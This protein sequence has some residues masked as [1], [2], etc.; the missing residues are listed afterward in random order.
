MNRIGTLLL[1]LFLSIYSFGQSLASLSDFQGRQNKLY[2]KNRMPHAGYWQQDV[3]Y[4]MKV[5]ID[6]KEESVAGTENLTY[7]NNSPDTLFEVFF[8]LYQ[9]AFTPGSYLHNSRTTEK[10]S[11][12]FGVHEAKG[13]GTA[14]N[15]L[16]VKQGKAFTEA[17]FEIDNSIMR[18]TLD[19]PIPPNSG[20]EFEIQFATYWDKGDKGN[21]RRRMK[22]FRHGG[23]G[24]SSFL[25]LDGVHWYPRI[26]VY[27]RKFGWT[28]DQHLG[29]EFYGD[30]GIYDVELNFPTEYIVEAT[31]L[32]V[33][34]KEAMPAELRTRVDISNYKTARDVYTNPIPADG[35]R[36]IW[37]YHAE[38]VHDFAFTADPT[39]RIGSVTWNGIECIALAQ[40]EHA[41]RWQN[42]AQ[43]VADVVRIYSNDIGMYTYPK[44]V[45]A[46]ARDGMEYPMITLNSGNWPG[47]QYVIAH[48]VGHNWFFGMVGNNE[49][50]RASMDEGFTQFLT[51]WSLRAIQNVKDRPNSIDDRT[52]YLGYMAHAMGEN[53]ARL[54]IHSDYF[55]SAERHGGGY[56]QVY[57]KTATM[58]YNLQYVLGDDLFLKAMQ[59]YFD[60]W[61]ICHP[62]WEDFRN[63]IIQYT[64][65]DLNWFF[66]AWIESTE[67]ID[68]KLVSVQHVGSDVYS[69]TFRRKGMAMPIDFTVTD[70]RGNRFDY[71]IPNNYFVKKTDAEVLPRWTGWGIVNPE[72]TTNV[73]IPEGIKD[74][75]I[76]PSGR[77]A[78][79]YRLDNQKK[80]P[81]EMNFDDLKQWPANFRSYQ[82]GWRPDLWYNAV[83]GFKAGLHFN[84]TYFGT[85]HNFRATAWYNTGVSLHDIPDSTVEGR[86]P[87]SYDLRYSNTLKGRVEWSVASRM[88]D[89]YDLHQLAF[90]S[91]WNSD[92]ISVAFKFSQRR[93]SDYLLNREFVNSGYDNWME[94][95]Y[96]HPYKYFRGR[97]NIEFGASA[98]TLFSD[99]NY[100]QL[101]LNVLNNTSVKALDFRTRTHFIWMDGA[102]IAPESRL[103]LAG[104]NTR[105]LM[106]NKYTRS[107]GWVPED[108]TGF[109]ST[110]NIFHY[111]GGLNLRGYSGYQATNYEGT[112][113]FFIYSGTRGASVNAE[114][115]A[116]RWLRSKTRK[117]NRYAQFDPYLFGDLGILGDP[118]NRYSGLRADAGFG[119]SVSIQT[120]RFNMAKPLILRIDV[121]LFLNRVPTNEDYLAFRYLLG[122]NMAF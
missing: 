114:L 9:N 108:W 51:S 45:A 121:P 78:D 44:M 29:K 7:W 88:L 111:G 34:A 33:N 119:A 20:I 122:L 67:T 23:E 31:G 46:D 104:A 16:R 4:R 101:Y 103:L 36:R 82:L 19:Q 61:K 70:K 42:T 68:Y 50:Y 113:T 120:G 72:Y 30:Y 57:Y 99:Y 115:S 69:I 22:S 64:K 52:V 118:D 59:H 96:V 58:L 100:A 84:G 3:H 63:S 76:D 81:I 27:D 28:T 6:D 102:E 13:L 91:P 98:S 86:D 56:G 93:N 79:V 18:V 110:T 11:T 43:F 47:H 35:T 66:D 92:R 116:G 75:Q 90:S 32:L 24:D 14:I 89:G 26:C 12:R 107:R 85:K 74:I 83:D 17:K 1:I 80:T 39:Y 40:E 53:T 94:A 71:H 8:H 49:T 38:N 106:D 65:C 25:H 10:I 95:R 77:L 117:L 87:I 55:N 37:K 48:E 5:F 41:H 105:D 60:T 73:I 112:D 109:G 15:G 62:Y 97:G 21:L 2:W 54:N